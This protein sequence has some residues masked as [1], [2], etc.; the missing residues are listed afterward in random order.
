MLQHKENRIRETASDLLPLI[1][2]IKGQEIS[3]N[4]VQRLIDFINNSFKYSE[5]GITIANN[6]TEFIVPVKNTLNYI[7]AQTTDDTMPNTEE[8]KA[9]KPHIPELGRY[10]LFYK[11]YIKLNYSARNC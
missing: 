4:L 3:M 11:Y 1:A 9:D 8:S 7:E 5:G 6:H 10:C 2:K